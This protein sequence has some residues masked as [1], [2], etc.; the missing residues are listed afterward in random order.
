MLTRGS[1]V[2]KKIIILNILFIFFFSNAVFA[3]SIIVNDSKIPFASV[4]IQNDTAKTEAEVP[5]HLSKSY[6]PSN[7]ANALS[8]VV[9]LKPEQFDEPFNVIRDS[10]SISV[11]ALSEDIVIKLLVYDDKE[12]SFVPVKR[13]VFDDFSAANILINTSWRFGPSGFLLCTF[14]MPAEGMYNYRLMIHKAELAE[15][16][17]IID[18]NLQL[19]DF[20]IIY[21][22]AVSFESILFNSFWDIYFDITKYSLPILP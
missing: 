13:N 7:S 15:D 8:Y 16:E 12:G 22:Q 5:V 4:S 10:F 9:I 18:E 3:S 17:Y 6:V 21:K 2:L 19:L 11:R 1:S 14:R 20:T